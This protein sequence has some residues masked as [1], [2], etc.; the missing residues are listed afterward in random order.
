[1]G[2]Y[3]EHVLPYVLNITMASRA[4]RPLRDQAVEGLRGEV[5]EIGFGTGLNLPHLPPTVTHLY[6]VEPS[7]R[8]LALA[9]RR[10]TEAP[11]AVEV[12]GLD[13]Q[14]LALAD[15]SADAVLCTWSLCTIP[16]PVAAL[17]EMR[18]VLRPE[19]TLHF[20]EHGRAPDD[21]V[22]AWQDRLNGLQNR[23]AG[24]CNLNRDI[25]ELVEAGGFRVTG[26]ETG[27]VTGIPKVTGWTFA[28]RAVAA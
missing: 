10:I 14:R 18:R 8:C 15:G 7:A 1:M 21:R 6:A 5:V 27:Y 23:L 19:G 9:A 26:L 28:G 11:C 2:L 20:V 24:G 17:R 13:G 4:I 16:D 22:R 3:R 25:P 12:A